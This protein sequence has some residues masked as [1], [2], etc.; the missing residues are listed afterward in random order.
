MYKIPCAGEMLEI[1]IEDELGIDVDNLSPDLQTQAALQSWWDAKYAEKS[2]EYGKLKV[3]VSANLGE[4]EIFIRNVL[5]TDPQ[6]LGVEL[7]PKKVTEGVVKAVM[8]QDER[9][10]EERI[11]LLKIEKEMNVLRAICRGYDTRSAILSTLGG[12]R[13]A[14]M[15][16]LMRSVI[17]GATELADSAE[18]GFGD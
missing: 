11:K 8:D 14:E 13:R 3:G 17:K 2:E 10:Q 12:M 9:V 1:D 15:E 6:K 7:E 4:R 16:S 18:E 5:A